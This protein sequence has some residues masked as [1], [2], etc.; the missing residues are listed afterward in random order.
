[1]PL[2]ATEF[3]KPLLDVGCLGKADCRLIRAVLGAKEL[4]LQ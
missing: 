2:G 3:T 1:M 4:G